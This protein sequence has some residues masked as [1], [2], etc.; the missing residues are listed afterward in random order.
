MEGLRNTTVVSQAM[1][2]AIVAK[3]TADAELKVKFPI[4]ANLRYL[5][6][7]SS[8]GLRAGLNFPVIGDVEAVVALEAHDGAT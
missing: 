6:L 7:E 8:V 5:K 3:I 1:L 4:L 2:D